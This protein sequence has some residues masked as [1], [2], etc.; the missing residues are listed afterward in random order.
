MNE[1]ADIALAIDKFKGAAGRY[2][3]LTRYYN[4]DHDLCFATEKF[5]NAFGSLFREF[6]FNLCAA[7]VDA[8]RDKLQI[9]EF[10]VDTGDIAA[11]EE[12][13]AI[14][15]ANRMNVRSGEIHKEACKTGDA[16]AIVWP[17]AS[18]KVTIYPNR[19][20]NCTV[21]YDAE[22]PGR[23][24]WAAK[25]WQTADKRFRLN[26]Y[27]ADRIERYITASKADPS[28]MLPDSLVPNSQRPEKFYTLPDAKA[29]TPFDTD[30]KSVIANPYGIVPVF[31]FAN[32]AGIGSEG[33]SEL[34]NAIPIQDALNK[35]VLDMIVAME[36]ASYR[37]RW[38]AGIEIEFDEAT[39]N[40]IP[41]F[42]A[43][44]E[45]L[46]IAEG[47]DAKFGDF[48]QTDLSQFLA[49]K[50]GFC[51]DLAA[52]TGTPPWYFM[53]GLSGG[54]PSGEALRKSEMRFVNKVR[55]RQ[56]SFGQ[57]W[58]DLIAFALRIENKGGDGRLFTAW[59]DPAPVS[60]TENLNNLLL[61]KELGATDE[62][63]L[64]EA[65][66]GEADIKS[67]TDAKAAQREQFARSFNA[68]EPASAA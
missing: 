7:I 5:R 11:A 20:D 60:E 48:Q 17:G 10:G 34:A 26:M 47:G 24:L 9:T 58:D 23:V 29:F 42:K 41:P 55:D 8:V 37:Q 52:V 63:L 19:A 45:R 36:F 67:M 13:W 46:W 15:T 18:G 31:H 22:V 6:A 61:K 66:Y 28:P 38:A 64:M 33:V 51:M 3:K 68:G 16:Y 25:H 12:A 14:W 57:V 4:G 53:Q 62:Q 56:A 27:Y 1:H 49:V 44:I 54:F 43:G 59:E 30:G 21:Q 32:N 65:G 35:S 50:E 2:A 40:P 39:G